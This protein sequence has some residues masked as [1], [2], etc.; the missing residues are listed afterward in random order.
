LL[1]AIILFVIIF[2]WQFYFNKDLGEINFKY[3]K[4]GFFPI[5]KFII[6]YGII[7]GFLL[8]TKINTL[9]LLI[10]PLTFIPTFKNKAIFS[11]I[12]I[13]SFFIFTIPIIEY[14]SVL[15]LWFKGIV[16]H[17]DLYGTGETGFVDFKLMSEHLANAIDYNPL[18]FAIIGLSVIF[19]IVRI[20]Q[21]KFDIHFKILLVLLLVQ[22]FELFMVMKHFN[23][24]YLIPIIPI[25]VVNIF[26][27]LQVVKL[28]KVALT[29][30]I[31]PF[32]IFIIYLNVDFTKFVASEY[33][34]VKTPTDINIYTFGCK[35]TIYGLRFGDE[36]SKRVNSAM[37]EKTH[38]K[39]YFYDIWT[40][41]LTTW[42][43]TLTID[44]LTKL[45]RKIY[46]YGFDGYLKD[47]STPFNMKRVSEGQ[48]LVEPQKHDTLNVK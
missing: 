1:G 18:I 24:H 11:G 17:T 32:I 45:N 20:F 35:S 14:Y 30:V 7:F 34:E 44:S 46:L 10:I 16:I 29:S 39:Q 27:M 22:F 40:Q 42:K 3:S 25:L 21:K 8:A 43:D 33:Q 6:L 31:L 15:F 37:L 4:K 38:G 12:A 48:Y 5:D 19:L 23:L 9:P 41:K 36:R 47:L 28:P 13:F 26:V 2:L